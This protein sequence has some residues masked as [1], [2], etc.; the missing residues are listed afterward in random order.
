MR[1]KLKV[2]F[3]MFFL[4][5]SKKVSSFFTLP[6]A[7]V[8]LLHSSRSWKLRHF[9][10]SVLLYF[11]IRQT[12]FLGE[13]W[14]THKGTDY[15]LWSY[16]LNPKNLCVLFLS[17][18]NLYILPQNN[19]Y[20]TYFYASPPKHCNLLENREDMFIFAFLF[21]TSVTDTS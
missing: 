16:H 12:P 19:L 5:S 21:P 1:W 4:W 14:F 11:C 20:T 7:T 9:W 17:S 15:C 8:T 2:I 3:P 10:H 6:N 18:I 13:L